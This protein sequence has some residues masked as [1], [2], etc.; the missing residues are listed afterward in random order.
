MINYNDLIGLRYEFGARPGDSNGFTDCFSLCM[1]VRTRLGL[2]MCLQDFDWV[3][4]QYSEETLSSMRIA[5]WLL[6]HGQLITESRPGAIFGVPGRAALFPMAVA[7]PDDNC[8]F[9]GSGKMVIAAPL[10][11]LAPKKFFWAD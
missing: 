6:T 9:I 11:A 7:L 10:L 2:K 5:R 4:E 8:L 3:Y 1:E